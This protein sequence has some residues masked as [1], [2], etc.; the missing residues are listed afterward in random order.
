MP[1][2]GERSLEQMREAFLT[3][4]YALLNEPAV[5]AS[6]RKLLTSGKLQLRGKAFNMI[7]GAMAP[8]VPQQ[9]G[10]S[11]TTIRVLSQVARPGQ[12]AGET[13]GVE[14]RT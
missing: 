4:A 11:G 7:L 12:P 10:S 13:V 5:F 14:V 8:H 2:P 3:N 9:K 6:L 1:D